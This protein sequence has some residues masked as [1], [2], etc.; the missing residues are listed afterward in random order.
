MQGLFG[1]NG[2]LDVV[3]GAI[4]DARNG[5]GRLVLLAGEPG[6]GKTRLADEICAR[7]W[8]FRILWGRAWEAGGAPAF[9]PWIEVLRPIVASA[10]PAW[11]AA[12]LGAEAATLSTLLPALRDR[13]P[14]L[15]PLPAEKVE[16]GRFLMFD[17]VRRLLSA[18][19]KNEPLLL[20]LDDLHVADDASLHLL[21]F[22]ARGLRGSRI[23]VLGAQRDADPA[24]SPERARLLASIAREGRRILLGRL[25]E[26]EVADLLGA[27]SGRAVGSDVV[28]H[29]MRVTEGTPLYVTELTQALLS[30][31]AEGILL[32]AVHMNLPTGL[33]VAIQ[34]RL[35]RLPTATLQVLS[36]AA[37]VGRE[38]RVETVC[39]LVDDTSVPEAAALLGTARAAG[40]LREAS[41]TLGHYRFS[42][43]LVRECV[44]RDLSDARRRALHERLARHFVKAGAPNAEIAHHF[45]LAGNCRA[46]LAQYAARA[47]H[48]AL[49][50]GAH[51]SAAA[52]FLAALGAQEQPSTENVQLELALAEAYRRG[53]DRERTNEFCERAAEHARSLE[54]P[55]LFARA[56]LQRGAEFTFGRTDKVLVSLLEEA[57]PLELAPS[58]R[59]RV[60]ARLAAARQ[61]AANFEE[62]LQLAREAV[63]L[64]RESGDRRALALVLRDARATYLPMDPLEERMRLD[65]ETL[66]IALE[67][68]DAHSVLHALRRLVNDRIE[69]GDIAA[70]EGHIDHYAR[71]A[72]ELREPRHRWFE[73]AALASIRTLQGRFDEAERLLVEAEAAS[74]PG[75]LAELAFLFTQKLVWCL[76]SRRDERLLEFDE[77]LARALSHESEPYLHWLRVLVH[78]RLGDLDFARSGFARIGSGYHPRFSG[79]SLTSGVAIALGEPALM[80]TIYE[81]LS[82]CESHYSP[83]MTFDGSHARALGSLSWALGRPDQAREHF[84]VALRENAKIGAKPWLAQTA[85]EYGRLLLESGNADD[86]ARASELHAQALVIA[87]ELDMP[88]LVRDLEGL[89]ASPVPDAPRTDAP[90]FTREGEYWTVRFAGESFRLKDNKGLQLVAHLVA[91][92]GSEFHVLDL[93]SLVDGGADS[94][95]VVQS[96]IASGPDQKARAAY[97]QKLDD[98]REDLDEAEARGDFGHCDRLR[99]QIDALSAELSRNLGLGGQARQSGGTVE[100]ARVN[101]QRRISD[102]V[103][104]LALL[105][106]ALGDV[107]SREIRTG[108]VCSFRG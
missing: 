74:G 105:S 58:L 55:D 61:P 46:E 45:G 82:S 95:R 30:G 85:F 25:D 12:T 63:A 9:W 8:G 43:I 7:A 29:V 50:V 71:V 19:A 59:A 27:S 72:A 92:P 56:A 39:E 4:A 38:F 90:R 67:T 1:R 68:G 52:H 6:I 108:V 76:A 28:R 88:G 35:E 32:T 93:T 18:H 23:L 107:L 41:A 77:M 3:D 69:Q 100:R 54:R 16:H 104:K 86:R 66:A 83:Q 91:H 106:P 34:S 36:C 2:E 5:L 70:A 42:H 53:G 51:E 17:A 98:L 89:H 57:M 22:V 26:T 47:G 48:D 49:G 79:Q 78:V 33:D 60:M 94:G 102:A 99:L 75:E 73:H 87:R 96:G 13:L 80:A 24:L 97:K 14:G 64:A 11:L 20:V 21:E 65:L 103:K 84:E 81:V 40:F 62:P 101:V 15:P 10:D 37:V 31:V 44:Y